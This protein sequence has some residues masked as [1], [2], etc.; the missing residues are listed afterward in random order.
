MGKASVTR[1]CGKAIEL[2]TFLPTESTCRR[3][4]YTAVLIQSS[5]SVLKLAKSLFADLARLWLIRRG[6]LYS[7]PLRKDRLS[8]AMQCSFSSSTTILLHY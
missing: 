1:R 8:N 3:T 7:K 4:K 5:Y 2:S 6:Q